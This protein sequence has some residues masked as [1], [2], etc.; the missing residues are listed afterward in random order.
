MPTHFM[1]FVQKTTA[2]RVEGGGNSYK[3]GEIRPLGGVNGEMKELLKRKKEKEEMC[4]LLSIFPHFW[5]NLCIKH[6]LIEQSDS[7]VK[8]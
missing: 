3:G 5:G 1:P 2:A 4:I 8:H 7:N 6:T